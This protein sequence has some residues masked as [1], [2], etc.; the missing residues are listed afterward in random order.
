MNKPPKPHRGGKES[1]GSK[2]C[3]TTNTKGVKK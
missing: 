1:G 3:K 2:N